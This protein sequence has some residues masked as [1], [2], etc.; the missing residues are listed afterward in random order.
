MIVFI[1]K[2]RSILKFIFKNI[3]LPGFPGGSVVKNPPTGDT[4][5]T[6]DPKRSH[7]PWDN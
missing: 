1:G 5:L 4:G 3:H 7:M 6:P 2:V